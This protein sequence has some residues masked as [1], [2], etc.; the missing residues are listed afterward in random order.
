L[1]KPCG[2]DELWVIWIVSDKDEWHPGFVAT[3]FQIIETSADGHYR[4]ILKRI[5]KNNAAIANGQKSEF[6]PT[7][8][9]ERTESRCLP[10][11]SR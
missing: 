11:L 3:Y 6:W 4:A 5:A 1:K 9:R 7:D 8:C 2:A 10:A